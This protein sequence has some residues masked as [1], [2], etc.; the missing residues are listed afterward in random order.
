MGDFVPAKRGRV[1]LGASSTGTATFV[2]DFEE[3]SER[4]Q[5]TPIYTVY[6]AYTRL[7]LL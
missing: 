2:I 3:V 1:E 4:A 5:D 7:F 6:P